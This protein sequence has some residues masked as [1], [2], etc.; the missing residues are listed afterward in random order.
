MHFHI[1]IANE[2]RL[3]TV[4]K[5]LRFRGE[6]EKKENFTSCLASCGTGA[7]VTNQTEEEEEKKLEYIFFKSKNRIKTFV[8][9][10]NFAMLKLITSF[11]LFASC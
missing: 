8:C 4:F 10:I 6:D 7:Q 11:S 5:K 2:E 1:I 9:E 3:G